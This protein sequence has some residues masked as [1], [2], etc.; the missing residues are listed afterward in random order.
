MDFGSSGFFIGVGTSFGSFGATLAQAV[1]LHI[2]CR[3]ER[4]ENRSTSAADRRVQRS[5]AS[6]SEQGEALRSAPDAVGQAKSVARNA[7][8]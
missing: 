6:S 2:H 8:A 5:P 7:K 4:S 1:G 3:F